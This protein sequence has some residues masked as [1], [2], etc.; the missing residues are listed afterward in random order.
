MSVTFGKIVLSSDNI[1]VPKHIL[2]KTPSRIHG[3]NKQDENDLRILG[4]E[5]IQTSGI[6]LKLPQIAMTTGQILFQRFYYSK[7]FIRYDMETTAMCCIFLASKIEESPRMIRDV[8][9]VFHHMK[10]IRGQSII[11]PMELSQYT[12]LK[13]RVLNAECLLLKVL[14][15]CVHVKQPH[16]LILMYLQLLGLEKNKN[17]MQCAW[18]NMNDSLRTDVFVRYKPEVI[19]CACV[20]LAGRKVNLPLPNNPPWYGVFNVEE[21]DMVDVSYRIMEL[22]NRPKVKFNSH[23]TKVFPTNFILSL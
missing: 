15:F 19:A 8:L 20:Y 4:C 23:S 13:T 10:Q 1:L 11:A 9:N 14:G 6:L 21:N 18:N 7:S 12:A 22:Y 16:K 2:D 3:L 5:S 17:L